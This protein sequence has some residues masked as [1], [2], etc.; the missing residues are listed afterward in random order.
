MPPF[1]PSIAS[2]DGLFIDALHAV[3][4]KVRPD[5]RAHVALL[6]GD[7]AGSVDDLQTELVDDAVLLVEHVPLKDSKA[8][9]RVGAPPHVHAGLVELQLH[10]ARRQ[11]IERHIDWYPEIQGEI[12]A[13]GKA[14]QLADP[15]PID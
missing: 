7:A 9:C 8:L 10:A 11:S 14:I 4:R 5:Q 2:S 6:G 1:A 15:L 12:R 3:R 13:N